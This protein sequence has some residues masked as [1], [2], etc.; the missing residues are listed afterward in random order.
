MKKIVI[1]ALLLSSCST[2]PP[3]NSGYI[4]TKDGRKFDLQKGKCGKWQDQGEYFTDK[5]VS[6]IIN[7]KNIKT[8]HLNY[9]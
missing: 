9:E 6:I 7:K 3:Y 8:I 1:V 2:V 4:E 5:G